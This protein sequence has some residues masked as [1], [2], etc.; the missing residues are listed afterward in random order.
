MLRTYITGFI[1]AGLS[2]RTHI[3]T[4]KIQ[5]LQLKHKIEES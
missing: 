3:H 5:G 4:H 1:K 2:K